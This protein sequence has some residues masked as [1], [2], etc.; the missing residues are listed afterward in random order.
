LTGQ[1]KD[2]SLG[3]DINQNRGSRLETATSSGA[4]S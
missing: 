4:A 3:P 1:T 2:Q